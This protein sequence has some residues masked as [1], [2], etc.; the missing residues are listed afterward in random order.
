LS[1]V[2]GKPPLGIHLVVSSQFPLVAVVHE[3]FAI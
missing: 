3:R 1:P 2:S